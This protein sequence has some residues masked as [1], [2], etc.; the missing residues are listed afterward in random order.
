MLKYNHGEKSM[1]VIFVIYASS[2]SLHE[3]KD[4]CHSNPGKKSSTM[5]VENTLYA[6]IHYL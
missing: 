5:T 1:K 4:T 3:K 6:V 2:E